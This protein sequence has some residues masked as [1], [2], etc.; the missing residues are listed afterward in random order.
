MN[1]DAAGTNMTAPMEPPPVS[2][3]K[4]TPRLRWNQAL[5]ILAKADPEPR[6]M[7]KAMAAKTMYSWVRFCTRVSTSSM[8]PIS[9]TPLKATHLAL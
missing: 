8:A 4:V 3:P 6:V 5:T 7:P 9:I 2:S 1:E